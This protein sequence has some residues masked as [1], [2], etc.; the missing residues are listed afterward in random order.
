M[1]FNKKKPLTRII[2][3]SLSALL[4]STG[5]Q[6]ISLDDA[7]NQQLEAPPGNVVCGRLLD[8]GANLTGALQDICARAF[9]LGASASSS[10]G[11]SAIPASLPSANIGLIDGAAPGDKEV[12]NRQSTDFKITANWSAFLT[13]ENEGLDKDQTEN[14]AAFDS[15]LNRILLGANYMPSN[16]WSFG[17]ALNMSNQ[18]S[19]FANGGE[20]SE[21]TAGLRLLASYNPADNLSLHL[22]GSYDKISADKMRATRFTDIF[23]DAPIYT[24]SATPESDYD[25]DRL[26]LTFRTYYDMNFGKFSL[27][28]QFGI[29]WVDTQYDSYNEVGASGLELTFHDDQHTSLQT[30]LGITG[31]YAIST[32]F[33][34][35][36]PQFNVVLRHEFEDEGR[37]IN[38]S[39]VQDLNATQFSFQAEDP[40]ANF[41]EAGIGGVFI[42]ADG[43]Q[44]FINV[45]TLL[46][47]EYYNSVVISVGLRREL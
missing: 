20:I 15:S 33:G 43:L 19:D 18:D 24:V 13:L 17:T 47:H 14:E 11:N 25:Y 30:S 38:V 29:D 36:I 28:P 27:V 1:T 7:I 9:P 34:V 44:S 12:G 40:D 46:A 2:P 16:T 32:G 8:A 45:H 26:G 5:V 41:I 4:F 31:T 6:A 42:F 23:N 37:E 22:L 10:G 3:A 35:F 21:D 39:F